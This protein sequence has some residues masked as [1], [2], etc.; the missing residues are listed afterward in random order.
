MTLISYC[1]GQNVGIGTNTP[2]YKLTIQTGNGYGL[3]HTNGTVS[4]GT[5]VDNFSGAGW[6]GTVS[7]HPLMFFTNSGAAQMTILQN[8]NIGIGTTTPA[9]NL[10]INHDF[11]ALRLSGNQSYLSFY[12]D[13]SYKGYLWNK[14]T[15]DMEL[16]TASSNTNGNL[17]LSIRGTPYLSIKNYGNVGI[18]TTTP[19]DK[20]TV[21]TATANYGLTHTDGTI[22][23]GSYVGFGAGWL[24]T[25]TSH[26]L[27]FFTNNGNAQMMIQ[28]NGQIAINGGPSSS[29]DLYSTLP[30]FTVNGTLTIK[31]ANSPFAEWIITS[32]LGELAFQKNGV[33]RA[34]VDNNGEWNSFSDISLKENIV[35]YKPVLNDIKNLK[36]STYRYK[37]N[38]TG[39]ISFGLI[40]QNVAQYFPEIISPLEDKDG[41]KLLGIAY[42]KTGVL[43]IKAIQEQQMIIE[44]QQQKIDQLEKRIMALEDLLR[45]YIRARKK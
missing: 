9:S 17:D 19:A 13:A 36:V 15:D 10:H 28:P 42:G 40:A 26:P 32:Y 20:L 3:V 44:K 25:K 21:L 34:W 33:A 27:Y 22:T 43:A 39:S 11:E 31:D 6:Y 41:R 8:G 12:N 45:K 14:G 18:G 24:G 16:G 7:N 5:Y 35:P 1:N 4:V 38:P 29:A 2:A 30:K 23:V 37:S